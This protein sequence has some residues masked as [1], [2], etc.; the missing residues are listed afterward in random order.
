MYYDLWCL[1]MPGGVWLACKCDNEI[2]NYIYLIGYEQDITRSHR[3][4]IWSY[5]LLLRVVRLGKE[6]SVGVI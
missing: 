2:N 6:F 3:G 1:P 5:L 4:F